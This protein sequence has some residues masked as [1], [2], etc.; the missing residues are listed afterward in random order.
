[1]G[2]RT[3]PNQEQHPT[4]VGVQ[5]V[6]LS[7]TKL[8][9][10]CCGP[11]R[12]RGLKEQHF[13]PS[14]PQWLVCCG[15]CGERRLGWEGMHRLVWA[16]VMGIQRQHLERTMFFFN[17]KIACEHVIMH[18]LWEPFIPRRTFNDTYRKNFSLGY[19]IAIFLFQLVVWGQLD[20]KIL[21]L[22]KIPSP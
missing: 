14:G 18:L 12:R 2:S 5:K 21:N 3:H 11:E 6:Q 9:M 13:T 16:G 20:N 15:L 7:G 4:E 8:G 17:F 10:R 19:T 22:N 1:M